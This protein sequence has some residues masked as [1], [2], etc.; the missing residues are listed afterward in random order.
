LPNEF[1]LRFLS[2]GKTVLV[3]AR[4]LPIKVSRVDLATGRR[5]PWKE[6]VPADPAGVQA[7]PAVKFSA[8][9]K[10]YAYSTGRI[11]SDLYVV[12]GLK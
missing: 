7:I 5:E 9:G 3:A 8:D 6:I 2:D 11:L 10:S 12:D 1:F 4:D